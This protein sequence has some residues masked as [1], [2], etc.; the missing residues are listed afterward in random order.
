M[1]TAAILLKQLL[2]IYTKKPAQTLC[3]TFSKKIHKNYKMTKRK[4][5]QP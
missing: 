5:L 4:S 1:Y 3:K 2:Y